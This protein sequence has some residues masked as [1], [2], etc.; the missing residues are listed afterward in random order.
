MSVNSE[1]PKAF[2]AFWSTLDDEL[3]QFP[4]RPMLERLARFST[5]FADVY[6]VEMTSTGP[7]RISGYFSV[8]KGEGPF[9]ALMFAPGY[10]SVVA[11]PHYN[12]RKRY[13]VLSL[14]HRGQRLSDQPFAATY[15]GLL[16]YGVDDPETYIFRQVVADCLRGAELLVGRPE[17][18][19]DRVAISGN[20]LALITA[21]R[22][23]MFSLV[24][25]GGLMF[26]RL[27]EVRDQSEAY[28][29]EEI[30]DY[31]RADPQKTESVGHTLSLFDPIYHVPSVKATTIYAVGD[32][33]SIGGP[34]WLAPLVQAHG[35]EVEQYQ[36]THEGGTDNDWTDAW[37]AN[38]FGVE[39]MSRFW[40][41]VA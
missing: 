38:R 31:L 3:A 22:R 30:N 37:I 28:P 35:G 32:Q 1:Q 18:D 33:G 26:H 21:A 2:E 25:T 39:P 29:I 8:P 40:R 4:A 20:D 7:Y 19:N 13:V 9:P 17:V 34:E 12:D 15:P 14:M 6:R 41:T 16:T 27:M 10:G 23:P 24:S 36:V 5:E 11:V